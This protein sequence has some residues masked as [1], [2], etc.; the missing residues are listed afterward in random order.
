[1]HALVME[2]VDGED[3]SLRIGRGAIP[4][5]DAVIIARQICDAL[6]AAHD[7]GIIHRDLKPANVMI[8][9]D[10]VVKV[11]DFGLAKPA[12]DELGADSLSHSPTT[13]AV[14]GTREGVLLGTA[15]YMSPEQARGRV[16]DKRTDIW[17]FG[18]LLYE[19]LTGRPAFG[20][21]TLSDTIAG[22]IEREPDWSALPKTSTPALK[23]L[24]ERC[25]QKDP[26]RR[27][28]DIGDARAELDDRQVAADLA[29]RP[30]AAPSPIKAVGLAAGAL[31]IAALAAGA[32]WLA[33]RSP[34]LAPAPVRLSVVAPPGT[35]FTMRDITEHPQFALSPQGDRLAVVAA[36]RGERQRIWIRSFETGVAQPLAGTDGANGLFWSPDGRSIGFQAEG[37]LKTVSLDGAAPRESRRSG[38]RRVAWGMGPGRHDPVL[39]RQRWI[40]DARA[41]N[42]WSGDAGHVVRRQPRRDRASLA[43]VSA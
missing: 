43:A 37:K 18:C 34:A 20:G 35:A 17:A 32:T 28:R 7:K 26:K 10:D 1:M 39:E 5:D 3:L 24:L 40:A 23:R 14:A 30:A 31:A 2:L 8:T 22:I 9:R 4:F 6:D 16:V 19:M 33:L 12:A 36:P 13:V 38:L 27:L 42:R 29:P 41:R 21:D 25:L 15:A 11:L